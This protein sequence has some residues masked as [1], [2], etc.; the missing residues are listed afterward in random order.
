LF[1][2]IT[3]ASPLN[4]DNILIGYYKGGANSVDTTGVAIQGQKLLTQNMVLQGFF[5][6]VTDVSGL[7]SGYSADG[8]GIS[9]SMYGLVK[10]STN[11][12]MLA[13]IQVFR[14]KTEINSPSGSS[15]ESDTHKDIEAIINFSPDSSYE[16][17]FLLGRDIGEDE[18]ETTYGIGGNFYITKEISIG[19]R[20]FQDTSEAEYTEKNL[21]LKYDFD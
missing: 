13:G 14:T 9:I 3:L 10:L 15:T 2:K 5:T 1:S 16:I 17:S 12:D 4:Y 8:R 18:N 11:V 20:Y 21:I 19:L 7:P 6:E